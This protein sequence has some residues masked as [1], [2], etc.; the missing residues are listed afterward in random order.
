MTRTMIDLMECDGRNLRAVQ[1]HWQLLHNLV[2]LE[3][4]DT[5][6]DVRTASTDI[7]GADAMYTA[8][9]VLVDGYLNLLIRPQQA[10][11][12]LDAR[13]PGPWEVD[14]ALKMLQHTFKPGK[15][16]VFHYTPERS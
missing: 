11:V 8:S 2:E 4:F 15:V 14:N 1:T 16:K 6:I 7:E 12:R 13:R 10:E 9:T 5:L 3:R